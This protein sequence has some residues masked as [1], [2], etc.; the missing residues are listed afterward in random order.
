LEINRALL[1]K[2]LVAAAVGAALIPVAL[3]ALRGYVIATAPILHPN[4]DDVPSTTRSAASPTWAGAV[5]EARQIALAGL[6][7]QN[8][9]GLSV[10]VGV[11]GEVVWA[12]G[13]GWANME[14][15]VPLVPETPL[16]IGT[17]SKM[18]TSAGVGLL[19][20]K[21]QLKLD[22]EIQTYVPTFP[23]KPWPV[24]LGQ[25]MA[26]LGGIRPDA[27]DEENLRDGC[28][29]VSDG[30]ERFAGG[31]LRHQPG[32]AYLYSSYG[33][34][35]V[36][37]AVE[38]AAGEPF[39][40]FMRGQVFEP[41]A[42]EN[43]KSDSGKVPIP[44]KAVHY[45]PRYGADPTYGPQGP[46]ELDL[47]CF[48]GSAAFLSTPTDLVR[49]VMAINGGKLLQSATVRLLQASQR[50]LSGSETGYGLGWD[51]ETVPLAGQQTRV[52]GYDG[53]L[54]GGPV[55]SVVWFPEHGIVVSVISNT[56][57]A[58]TSSL[59]L[60]LAEAFVGHTKKSTGK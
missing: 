16:R 53:E 22:E 32:T 2:F 20:E 5:T 6:I 54:M 27:G 55:S 38:H 25:V 14:E 44:N 52:V 10:A 42:M 12:Q 18:L 21:G 45:F 40:S 31:D 28:E 58:G 26:H 29:T 48:A 9:P 7:T 3:L 41:L 30:L 43:T 15:R 35:L 24:T 57:H 1:R 47:S 11:N 13:F 33:W 49:F 34:I 4:P 19:L 23:K 39:H 17:A 56:S 46:T 60:S 50:T 59:T 36:S 8:L 51:L 37:A